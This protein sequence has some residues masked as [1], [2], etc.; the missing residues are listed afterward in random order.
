EIYSSILERM[1]AA[2]G[3]EAATLSSQTLISNSANVII[4]A[5]TDEPVVDRDSADRAAFTDTHRAWRLAVEPHFFETI[6]IKVERG[7]S[8]DDRDNATAAS[9]AVVNHALARQLFQTDDVVG[10]RFRTESRSGP[11][12][13]EIVGVCTDAVYASLRDMKTP[14]MYVAHRQHGAGLM[15]F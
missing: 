10:R 11:P 1:R 7:R 6:G 12:S 2:P 4:A 9:V 3:V 13:Y 15:T 14:T 5:R 8:V